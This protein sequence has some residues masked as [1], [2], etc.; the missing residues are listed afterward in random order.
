VDRFDGVDAC[1]APVLDPSEVADHP[2]MAARQSV[3]RSGGV[4]QP[5]VAPR[6]SRTPGSVG[7]ACHPGEHDYDDVVADWSGR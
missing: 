5:G 7:R 4:P 1:V 3:V 6:F 2:H